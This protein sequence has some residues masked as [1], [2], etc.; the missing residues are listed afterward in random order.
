MKGCVSLVAFFMRAH[1]PNRDTNPPFKTQIVADS[2][3]VGGDMVVTRNDLGKTNSLY[4]HSDT[5]T[6]KNC[7][8][9][10]NSAQIVSIFSVSECLCDLLAIIKA[11]LKPISQNFGKFNFQR[12]IV[13]I[14]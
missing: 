1:Q 5:A 13:R 2:I 10:Y 3:V 12:C 14:E 6:P 9:K 7:L 11:N 8:S 4:Q